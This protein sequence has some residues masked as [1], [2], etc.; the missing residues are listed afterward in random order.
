MGRGFVVLTR[1][2]ESPP[3]VDRK[4]PAVPE[5][6]VGTQVHQPLDVHGRL[7]AEV[8]LDGVTAVDDV[9]K[10]VDL[11]VGEV[12]DAGVRIHVGLGEDLLAG[13]QPDPVDVGQRDLHP[14]V[15]WQI[16]AGYSRQAYLL[17]GA[18]NP[19]GFLTLSLF[20]TGIFTDNS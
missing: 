7:A 9:A 3:S 11:L 13:G 1:S 2:Q 20:M 4:T 15:F 18:Y 19:P 10:T 5:T 8:A 6:P 16:N 17:A 12:A 14:F